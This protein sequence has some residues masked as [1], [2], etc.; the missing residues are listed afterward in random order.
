[1][2]QTNV[3]VRKVFTLMRSF[4]HEIP[5]PHSQ[6]WLDGWDALSVP[7]EIAFFFATFKTIKNLQALDRDLKECK[8]FS[9][10]ILL[11]RFYERYDVELRNT[12]ES[13]FECI[14]YSAGCFGNITK[15]C[16]TLWKF[17]DISLAALTCFL[18]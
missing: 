1:M 6:C 18:L 10:Y 11:L 9:N 15:I 7:F 3:H 13:I 8:Q 16:R 5:K 12:Q 14:P 4:S 17:M 2:R